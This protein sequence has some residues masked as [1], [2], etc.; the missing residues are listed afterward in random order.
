MNLSQLISTIQSTHEC[1]Q[2]YAHQQVNNSLTIRNWLTGFYLFHFEQNG[3]DR[4]VYGAKLYKTIAANLKEKQLK[5]FS[6]TALNQYRQFYL[7]YPDFIQTV[8]EL[9]SKM[10]FSIIQTVSKQLQLSDNK[11]ITKSEAK[12]FVST[13][14]FAM[15]KRKRLL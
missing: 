14:I 11:E 15:L 10:N 8:S 7:T 13:S 1:A 6:F 9:F 3:E 12:S 5:G 4:A 2:R